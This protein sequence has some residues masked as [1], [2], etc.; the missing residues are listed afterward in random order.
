MP[1]AWAL[2]SLLPASSPAIT[3]LVAL[4][5]EPVTLAPKFFKILVNLSLE[6]ENSPVKTIV[7]LDNGP[8]ISFV[9][10]FVFFCWFSFCSI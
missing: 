1:K 9:G 6:I 5:T 3:Q 8:I 7:S 4:E 10:D 2:S